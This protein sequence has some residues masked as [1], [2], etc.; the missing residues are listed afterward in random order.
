MLLHALGFGVDAFR[1]YSRLRLLESSPE[2]RMPGAT[3]TL[4]LA[5]EMLDAV[6]GRAAALG[7]AV[8]G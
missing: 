5:P 3:G 2:S 1:L 6:L 4:R 7:G 8:E